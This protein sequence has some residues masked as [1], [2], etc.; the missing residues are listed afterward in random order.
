MRYSKYVERMLS[1]RSLCTTLTQ[2]VT[3]TDFILLILGSL[4]HDLSALPSVDLQHA[5]L[6]T[7][8]WHNTELCTRNG[9]L[10]HS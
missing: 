10:K 1:S 8:S 4:R 5:L 9:H 7:L 3:S 6:E 2:A